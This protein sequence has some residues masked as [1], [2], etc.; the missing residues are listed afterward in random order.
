MAVTTRSASSSAPDASF[1]PVSVKVS[2]WSVA[3]EA[4][5]SAERLEEVPVGHQAHA[6][7]PRVVAGL[8]VGVDVIAG[9][10]LPL[11]GL[12]DQRLHEA[13]PAPAELEDQHR[14]QH[15]LP[16]HDRVGGLGRQQAADEVG[17]RVL[18]GQRDDVAGRAL[19]HRHVLRGLRHRRDERDRGRAA[20]D[21]HHALA[22]VVDVVGPALRV[23]DLG[24]G[25]ARCRGSPACRARRSGSSRCT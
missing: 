21:H 25:S 20:A 14:D 19:E 23:H 7:V 1:R 13:R 2:I 4:L 18:R 16:A 3:I 6:L 10:E 24:P 11:D 9:R 17:D 22:G 5:P 12:A 15:V 8:E